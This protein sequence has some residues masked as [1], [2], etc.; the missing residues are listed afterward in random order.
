[1]SSVVMTLALPESTGAP[2]MAYFFAQAFL[3][4]G[5]QVVLAHGPDP[6]AN[7]NGGGDSILGPMREIGVQTVPVDG[8]AFPLTGAVSRRVA[9]IASE[10][11]ATSVIG[12]QQR[13][14]AV[15]L[16]AARFRKSP[17]HHLGSEPTTRSAASGRCD[18]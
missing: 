5:H 18:V 10:H 12:F 14:R 11:R 9:E 6:A 1:M 13:D 17:R 7:G 16:K 3:R 8:L 2:R 15:A 4:S